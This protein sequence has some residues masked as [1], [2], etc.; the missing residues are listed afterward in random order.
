MRKA[1]PHIFLTWFIF[2]AS[3]A[4]NVGPLA[5][6]PRLSSKVRSPAYVDRIFLPSQS[7]K[8]VVMRIRADQG[9][10]PAAETLQKLADAAELMHRKRTYPISNACYR[11]SNDLSKQAQGTLK[12]ASKECFGILY[13]H[14]LSSHTEPMRK[15]WE[16]PIIWGNHWITYIKTQGHHIAMDGTAMDYLSGGAKPI[17]A[18]LLISRTPE[19][20][21]RMLRHYYGGAAWDLSDAGGKNKI[22][23]LPTVAHE[24]E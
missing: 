7:R 19:G 23:R 21:E 14:S 1:P 10:T 6:L 2:V 8:P 5:A 20:L 3:S 9:A 22:G 15:G 12:G 13:C 24:G 18:E 17:S 11:V 16:Q 4:V